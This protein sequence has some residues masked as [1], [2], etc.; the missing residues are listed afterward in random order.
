M[1]VIRMLFPLAAGFL[2]LYPVL[3]QGASF[4]ES[5]AEVLRLEEVGRQKFLKGDPHWDDLIADGAYMVRWDGAVVSYKKGEALP[6]VPMK[7]MKLSEME[8]RGYGE[9]VVVTG[10]GEGEGE[11][12]DKKPFSFKSRFLNV[13]KKLDGEWKIV[14]SQNTVVQPQKA[15]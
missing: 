12:H 15:K 9:V 1:N 13:W 10:L 14:L 2:L 5:E 4:P 11:T 8:A 3:M 6:A 7:S